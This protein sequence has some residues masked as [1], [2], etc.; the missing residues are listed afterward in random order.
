M[1]PA[2]QFYLWTYTSNI[3][4]SW[5]NEWCFGPFDHFWSLAV[6]EH[7]YFVWPAV[8]FFLTRRRL[9]AVCIGAIVFVTAVRTIAAMNPHWDT[10]VDVLTIFRADSLAMGALLAIVLN[11]QMHPSLIRSIAWIV[12]LTSFPLLIGVALTAKRFLGV[13]NTLCSLFFM[14]AMA[15]LLTNTKRSLFAITFESTPLRCLGKYSYGNVRRA[16][17]SCDNFAIIWELELA[18]IESACSKCNLRRRNV[19]L[20]HMRCHRLLSSS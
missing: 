8:V 4:M 2:E 15:I 5:L 11:S 13:P 19:R 6:E 17:S 16:A 9:V 12:A 3:R 10:A 18:T 14:A 7:F 1:P 20:D